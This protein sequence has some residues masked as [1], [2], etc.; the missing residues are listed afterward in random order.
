M[1]TNSI[2]LSHFTCNLRRSLESAL[3][4]PVQ[5]N[6]LTRKHH[7][8]DILVYN[9]RSK[10]R[11]ECWT[12]IRWF[13]AGCC[14]PQASVHL[15]LQPH[16]R[17]LA[18]RRGSFGAGLGEGGVLPRPRKGSFPV[19]T[20][21]RLL[22]PGALP[23]RPGPRRRPAPRRAAPQRRPAGRSV[24]A[25]APPP[26][27]AAPAPRQ[28]SPRPRQPSAPSQLSR[29]A[30]SSPS[31]AGGRSNSWVCTESA[32]PAPQ[33][34][35]AAQAMARPPETRGREVEGCGAQSS[36]R[37]RGAVT[38]P[39]KSCFPGGGPDG[40]ARR[41]RVLKGRA[42]HDAKCRSPQMPPGTPGSALGSPGL[43]WVLVFG[44]KF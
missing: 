3:N 37:P 28:H 2:L 43:C 5:D 33:L 21:Q 38:Q 29:M 30:H 10:G 18:E 40:T 22:P 27:P 16:S 36:A 35:A 7:I 17:F 20:T 13:H 25:G 11:Q 19:G 14:F 31:S 8:A 26:L 41:T 23:H 1:I 24:R 15:T 39:R 9:T 34:P 32:P 42:L 12:N 4:T 6:L 44:F